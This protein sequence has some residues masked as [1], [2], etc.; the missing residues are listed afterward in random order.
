MSSSMSL[1]RKRIFPPVEDA[2]VDLRSPSALDARQSLAEGLSWLCQRSWYTAADR[3]NYLEQLMFHELGFDAD[4]ARRSKKLKAERLPCFTLVKWDDLAPL[5]CLQGSFGSLPP[6][7]EDAAP[8]LCLLPFS[9]HREFKFNGWMKLDVNVDPRFE[10]GIVPRYLIESVARL[11]CSRVLYRSKVHSGKRIEYQVGFKALAPSQCQLTKAKVYNRGGVLLVV[12]EF[13]LGGVLS[14]DNAA[15]LFADMISAAETNQNKQQRVHG[16][17][18]NIDRHYFYSYNPVTKRFTQGKIFLTDALHRMDH[19]ERLG[20]VID[21]LFS[22][23][24]DALKEYIC[25][26]RNMCALRTEMRTGNEHGQNAAVPPVSS[27]LN[28]DKHQSISL[29]QTLPSG[30]SFSQWQTAHDRLCEAQRLMQRPQSK[31]QLSVAEINTRGETGL[32]LVQDGVALL[33][34]LSLTGGCQG[35]RDYADPQNTEQLL[36]YIEAKSVR[37]E[38]ALVVEWRRKATS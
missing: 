3:L 25:H 1:K 10:P 35:E 17:L 2:F 6:C 19:L 27:S 14:N 36:A 34:R 28:P 24:V 9:L 15:L 22:V 16:M 29:K 18:T 13:N 23:C 31:N 21:Y 12:A 38:E 33:P 11:F 26:C 20:E 32:G 7:G 30:P 8:P 37:A 5:Y 4:D